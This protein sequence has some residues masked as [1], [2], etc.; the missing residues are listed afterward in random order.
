MTQADWALQVVPD[1]CP[2]C[3]ARWMGWPA[4][5]AI[6]QDTPIS[7]FLDG[8]FVL[9]LRSAR[10]TAIANGDIHLAQNIDMRI[11][12]EAPDAP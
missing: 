7:Q 4:V 3:G 11:P 8:E 10:D 6:V 9:F 2:R 1:L 5:G 12:D